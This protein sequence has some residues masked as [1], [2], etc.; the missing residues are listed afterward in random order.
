MILDSLKKSFLFDLSCKS[1]LVN[2]LC[3]LFRNNYDVIVVCEDQVA[4]ASV[5]VKIAFS[6]SKCLHLRRKM[7][8]CLSGCRPEIREDFRQ[9]KA[10]FPRID[11][12]QFVNALRARIANL[13]GP[14]LR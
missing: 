11:K 8:S 7:N 10:F 14:Y 6:G 9:P 3:D 1:L 4:R 5:Y 13:S 12:P 2:F